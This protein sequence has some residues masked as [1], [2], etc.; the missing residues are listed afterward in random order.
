MALTPTALSAVNARDVDKRRQLIVAELSRARPGVDWR[1]GAL[2]DLVVE[3]LAAMLTAFSQDADRLRR[4]STI[5]GITADPTLADDDLVDAVLSNYGVTRRGA[6]AARGTATI[7]LDA[8]TPVVISSGSQF[9]ANGVLFTADHAVSARV[10]AATVVGVDDVVVRPLTDGRYGFDVPVTAA[11]T[12]AVGAVRLGA[13]LTPQFAVPHMIDCLA[14][15]DFTGGG[16]RENNDQLLARLRAGTSPKGWSSRPAIEAMVRGVVPDLVYAVTLGAGDDGMTRSRRGLLPAARPGYVDLIA[17]TS[18]QARRDEITAE[19]VLIERNSGAGIWQVFL[20][21]D[22]AAGIYEVVAA[23]YPGGAS[24][25]TLVFDRRTASP[26]SPPGLTD[27]GGDMEVAFSS[28]QAATLRFSDPGVVLDDS[29]APGATRSFVLTRLGMPAIDQVQDV[30]GGPD[31]V[32]PGIDLLVKAP[33]P[34]F[35]SVGLDLER[36]ATAPDVNVPAVV[37]AI[38]SRCNSARPTGALRAASLI[39]AA[40]TA[41]PAGAVVTRLELIGRLLNPDLTRSVLVGRPDLIA[42]NDPARGV[43][44]RTV[45]FFLDAADVAVTIRG[46]LVNS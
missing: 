9:I 13:P 10:S 11:T 35:V 8:P 46:S 40:Q 2:G 21:R 16:D 42:P 4:A 30:L 24:P 31:V 20:D 28:V 23:A 33:V 7:V 44:P 38:V 39:A 32:G 15:S 18:A 22:Q 25:M 12:G 26:T 19:A 6:A 34:C 17:R 29:A 14:A 3:P 37:S 45:A 1:R 36:A 27:P 5:A 41:M 43:S